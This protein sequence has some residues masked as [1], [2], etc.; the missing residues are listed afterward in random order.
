[1]I[2][3]KNELN[4]G[5]YAAVT[6][7]ECPLLVLAGAGTGKTRVITYRI[8][9]LIKV[10]GIQPDNILAV[11]FTNKAAE[12]MKTRLFGLVGPSAYSVWMGTFHS[13]CLRLLRRD[14][15][16]VGLQGGFGVIDQDDRL[17][18]M[19]SVVKDLKIDH[20][21]YPPKQYMHRISW[22]KNTKP[23]VDSMPPD[24]ATFHRL[25]EVFNEYQHRL[26]QQ[27]LIDFD[28]M[29]ALT[30]RML[31]ANPQ[32]RDHYRSI[33][34]YI[35]VDEYQDT[36]GIQFL[37]LQL[38]SGENGK[39]CVVGDDDQSIY[40]WRGADIRNIL[41]FDKHFSG[42]ETVKLTDNY[43][44][45]ADI[46]ARANSL[47]NNNRM[48]KG[49]ELVPFVKEEG[50]VE[51]R[52]AMN[53]AAEAEF[54]TS[55]IEKYMEEGHSLKDT[56]VLYRTNAQ[57][58]NFEVNL[59]K[60][61]IPYKVIGGTAFY[62]RRE[63]KDILS[64][65]RFFDNA[66]DTVSFARS[67]KFPG[68]GIGDGTI[69]KL[70]RYSISNGM[71]L[72]EGTKNM[73]GSL[74]ANMRRGLEGY[75]RLMDH[76]AGLGKVSDMVNDIIEM[77][78]YKEYL[79]KFESKEE[80]EKRAGNIDELFNAAVAFE[81]ANP[82]GTL[83]DFLATTSL[84]TSTDEDTGDR[85][86]LMTIHS[87]KGLEFDVV[88]LTG[89]ENGLFP[90][91]SSIDEPEQ[92]EEERR[93]CYVGVTRA[94][95]H[96]YVTN[97]ENRIIYG[98]RNMTTRSYFLDEMGFKEPE[99]FRAKSPSFANSK[100]NVKKP[101]NKKSGGSTGKAGKRVQHEKFGEGII[102][103][104]SGDGASEKA[105]VFFKDAGGLKKIVT[106]FLTFLD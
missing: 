90:L 85:V 40:G 4:D 61:G 47:I 86:S 70:R 52:S 30:I 57:S 26:D 48:R 62:Q 54:V 14:G 24:A 73:G 103:S 27:Y 95:K 80:A 12:E 69:E 15:H 28:D 77:T 45:T 33:F 35:L 21:K 98:K 83:T 10:C 91:H 78:E 39:I 93:L 104:V 19:R 74:S 94:K 5:Q 76:L 100:V 56:A 17:S 72:L 43:R 36:N 97:A 89:L 82:D 84:T 50:T 38:L 16:L 99:W 8:A 25:D 29:L 18:L 20:K 22:F 49:K 105:E 1:M 75:V 60:K 23:Y 9:Y 53:E 34:K 6:S 44:S 68:R 63:I 2:D 96:L 7:T 59:N 32:T 71:N 37:F 67:L 3:F 42:V 106:S 79:K 46:L 51:Y 88:F 58:R 87:A 66:Y 102:I 41:E 101:G 31:Q 11:T 65:L 92:M 13:I 64:Y 81:E 55:T